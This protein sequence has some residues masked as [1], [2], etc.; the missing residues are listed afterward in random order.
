MT[1]ECENL[2]TQYFYKTIILDAFFRLHDDDDM[3]A[4]VGVT[5]TTL[6]PTAYDHPTNPKIKL[7]DLP[8]IGTTNYPD[9]ETYCK[10]LKLEQFH[11]FLI[12]SSSRFT[13]NDSQLAKEIGSMNKKFFFIRAKID[14]DVEAAKRKKTFNEDAVLRKIRSSCST[15]LAGLLR[16]EDDIFLISSHYPAKWD[17]L[18]LSQ[19]TQGRLG[20][21]SMFLFPYKACA[22]QGGLDPTT[23]SCVV[24]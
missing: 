8:G 3:A 19:A 24:F 9:L 2:H 13:K 21:L 23:Q 14:Q 22:R 18:R 17:F 16:N 4:P 5:A 15:N 6:E 10:E 7:W 20:G 11:A 1:K 12:F